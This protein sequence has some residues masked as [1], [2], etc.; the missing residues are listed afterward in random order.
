MLKTIKLTKEEQ[1]GY[2]KLLF[3]STENTQ[4]IKHQLE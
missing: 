4:I 1:Q 3:Q 2:Y